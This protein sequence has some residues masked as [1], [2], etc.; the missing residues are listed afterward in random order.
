L[1][2]P[3]GKWFPYRFSPY[4]HDPERSRGHWIKNNVNVGDSAYVEGGVGKLVQ[5]NDGKTVYTTDVDAAIFTRI[6][7]RYEAKE[8]TDGNEE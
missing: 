8:D 2:R 4:R 5:R 3:S 7:P 1:R 6:H